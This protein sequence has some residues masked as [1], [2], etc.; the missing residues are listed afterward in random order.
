MQEI[1]DSSTTFECAAIQ[2]AGTEMRCRARFQ[3]SKPWSCRADETLYV[4][5]CQGVLPLQSNWRKDV[6]VNTRQ[7]A[8]E[9]LSHVSLYGCAFPYNLNWLGRDWSPLG[10]F[11][12]EHPLNVVDV[13]ARGASLGELQPLQKF[14]NY[15]AFDADSAEASRLESEHDQGFKSFRIFPYFVG[16]REGAVTF[17]LFDTPACSP[18][19]A[20]APVP[21]NL[22]Y[23][24]SRSSAASRWNRKRSIVFLRRS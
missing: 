21:C 1:D 3:A 2:R 14:I 23:R 7:L 17:H 10:W 4:E 19:L 22:R 24:V 5:A 6:G 18:H 12:N 20:L 16:G 13:G 9:L 11:L 15:F 8:R